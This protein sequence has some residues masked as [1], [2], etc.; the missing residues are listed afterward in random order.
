MVKNVRES[1]Y[2]NL[3]EEKGRYF[4]VDLLGQGPYAVVLE[5]GNW[6]LSGGV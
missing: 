5:G 4:A 3:D 1:F 6:R 2:K